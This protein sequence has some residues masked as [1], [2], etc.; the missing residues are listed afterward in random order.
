MCTICQTKLN[1]TISSPDKLLTHLISIL[2]ERGGG[3]F[4]RKHPYPHPLPP[5]LPC[6]GLE[7]GY[8][9]IEETASRRSAMGGGSEG[10]GIG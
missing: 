6:F 9:F 7:S 3:G 2:W 5:K 4:I 8:W 10:G 1:Q